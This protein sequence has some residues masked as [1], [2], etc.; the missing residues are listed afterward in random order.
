MPRK[1]KPKTTDVPVTPAEGASPTIVPDAG[2]PTEATPT[3]HLGTK[4]RPAFIAPTATTQNLAAAAEAVTEHHPAASTETQRA[5]ARSTVV[6]PGITLP[7]IPAVRPPTTQARVPVVLSPL[8][9]RPDNKQLSKHP[10]NPIVVIPA[11]QHHD[12]V[13]MRVPPTP[14]PHVR[15]RTHRLTLATVLVLALVLL[16]AFVPVARG[17]G[18][19]LPN[20]VPLADARAY[21]TPT[22]SP[23]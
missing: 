22:P 15:A 17:A 11:A 5:I 7:S 19:G 12:T 13:P 10:T 23:T 18:L 16:V 9:L 21:P 20:W 2:M 3:T 1:P 14:H 4:P 8:G 6:M